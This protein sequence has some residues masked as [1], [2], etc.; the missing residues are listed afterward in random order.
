MAIMK[1]CEGYEGSK[2]P[3]TMVKHCILVGYIVLMKGEGLTNEFIDIDNFI[4][5]LTSSMK[6]KMLSSASVKLAGD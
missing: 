1:G 3:F 5:S 2:Q 4:P 6:P